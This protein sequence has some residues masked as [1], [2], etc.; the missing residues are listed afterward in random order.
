LRHLKPHNQPN[1]EVA[2]AG[3]VT[4]ARYKDG[5]Y[6]ADGLYGGLPSRLTVTLKISKDIIEGVSVQT[7]A[8]DPISLDLQRRFAE[9]VPSA[10][11]GKPLREVRVGKL[12][13]SSVTPDGFNA[14]VQRIRSQ[15]AR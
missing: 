4:T 3:T 7:H 6:T 11:L 15:A 8:T 12:A 1:D 9:A 13:G 2:Q 5:T 14:A 10:V